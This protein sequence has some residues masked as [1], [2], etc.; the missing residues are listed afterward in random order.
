MSV[1]SLTVYRKTEE[2][3]YKVYPRLTNFPKSE[4]FS[5]CQSIKENFFDLL[6]NISLG[7]SVKSKRK[8]YLQEADGHLQILKVLIK[9][10]KQRKYISVGFFR[11][12]DLELTEINKLLS[13]Y[14]RSVNK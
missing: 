14:I 9:L 1:Q 8:I 3:L 6:K 12:V 11:E 10:S 2:L 5:L 7:N 13:G 4:K